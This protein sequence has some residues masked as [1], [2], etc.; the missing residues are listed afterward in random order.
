MSGFLRHLMRFNPF[1]GIELRSWGDSV[2]VFKKTRG[3]DKRG[4]GLGVGGG[5]QYRKLVFIHKYD[6]IT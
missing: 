6:I 5:F 4:Y 2:V 1:F 3:A